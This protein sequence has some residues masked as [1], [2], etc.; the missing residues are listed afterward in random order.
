MLMPLPCVD[1]GVF[2]RGGGVQARLLENSSNSVFKFLNIFYTGL[3][4]KAKPFPRFQRGSN[5]FQEGSNISVG[6]QILISIETHRTC[7]FPWGVQIPS[8]PPPSG[9]A[10]GYD[11]KL[12]YIIYMYIY[13][14]S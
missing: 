14:V 7:D 13:F 6:V 10:H 1:P 5:I 9:S 3:S 11:R 12:I 8:P 2:I 4:K